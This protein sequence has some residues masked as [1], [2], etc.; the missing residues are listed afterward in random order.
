M[1][2]EQLFNGRKLRNPWLN[3]N[4]GLSNPSASI[5][6]ISNIVLIKINQDLGNLV[7]TYNINKA[8]FDKDDQRLVILTETAFTIISEENRLKYY[9]PAN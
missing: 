4:N 9:S 3:N 5:I 2:K 6:S 8:Y 1:T 7:R